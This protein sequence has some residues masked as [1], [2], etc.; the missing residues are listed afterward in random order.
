MH[1]ASFVFQLCALNSSTRSLTMSGYSWGSSNPREY[2]AATISGRVHRRLERKRSFQYRRGTPFTRFTT[3]VDTDEA[4]NDVQLVTPHRGVEEF[5]PLLRGSVGD[6]IHRDRHTMA[7]QCKIS[8]CVGNPP[9]SV[10]HSLFPDV[11]F[12]CPRQ[13]ITAKRVVDVHRWRKVGQKTSGLSYYR[14]V[15]CE[16]R[17]RVNEDETTFKTPGTMEYRQECPRGCPGSPKTQTSRLP[18]R[19]SRRVH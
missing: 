13:N 19:R 1:S 17:K 3:S 10:I 12:C 18:P 7:H 6:Y 5:A 14:C 4:F 16:I 8:S 9:C 15:K 11:V 2:S